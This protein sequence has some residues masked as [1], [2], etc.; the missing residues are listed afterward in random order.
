MAQPP[1]ISRFFSGKNNVKE[2][3]WQ[4]KFNSAEDL[5][6]KAESINEI[7]IPETFL[8]M[9]NPTFLIRHPALVFESI[10]RVRLAIEGKEQAKTDV[11]SVPLDP[12]LRW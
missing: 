2:P 7:V 8:P 9:W 5:E 10:Y 1:A 12:T 3:A 11:A 6:Y 4:V